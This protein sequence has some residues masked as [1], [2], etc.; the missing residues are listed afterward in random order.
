MGR[1]DQDQISLP[2]PSIG[3][4]P[5][6]VFTFSRSQL[7]L[8]GEL[9]T[10]LAMV[11]DVCLPTWVIACPLLRSSS[12]DP[13][14]GTTTGYATSP[15]AIVKDVVIERKDQLPMTGDCTVYLNRFGTRTL[16]LP[17][18]LF[19]YQQGPN[20][21]VVCFWLATCYS[22]ELGRVERVELKQK[23]KTTCPF[24]HDRRS[25]ATQFAHAIW[26]KPFCGLFLHLTIPLDIGDA[27]PVLIIGTSTA[28][29]QHSS[30]VPSRTILLSTNLSISSITVG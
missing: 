3:S 2:V 28:V 1:T 12:S 9:L 26:S 27:D 13:P 4:D 8:L 20:A 15:S 11:E 17:T 18:S 21:S 19:P 14:L 22:N 25:R 30:A 5:H 6:C 23:K 16:P 7:L 29:Q 10:V 24:V